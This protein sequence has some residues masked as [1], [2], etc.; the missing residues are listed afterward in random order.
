M[1]IVLLVCFVIC[2]YWL[3][4]GPLLS[5]PIYVNLALYEAEMK[6]YEAER[7]LSDER[8]AKISQLE[9]HLVSNHHF[10]SL[11]FSG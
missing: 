2:V 11:C 4:L 8:L 3:F 9:E 6:R 7:K 10:S 1:Y 5:I